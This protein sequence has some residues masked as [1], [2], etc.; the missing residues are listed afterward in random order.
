MKHLF[1]LFFICFSINANE[2]DCENVNTRGFITGNF[3]NM[4][5]EPSS[6][7]DSIGTLNKY[8]GVFIL[9]KTKVK[10]KIGKSENYWF[11][12]YFEYGIKNEPFWIF[13]DYVE[14]GDF[15]LKKIVSEIP[16]HS[17][18]SKIY[19]IISNK[20][21]NQGY[22]SNIPPGT[23]PLCTLWSYE[24]FENCIICIGLYTTVYKIDSISE[25]KNMIKIQTT[26][27]A[28]DFIEIPTGSK[29]SFEI[30]LGNDTINI[31]GAS[32]FR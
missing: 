22:W 21:E 28:S 9:E 32:Y 18:S 3:V 16:S 19:N 7:S 2:I 20:K 29:H 10:F 13:G 31:D 23:D 26:V 8:M 15:N 14:Y 11:K 30:E 27:Y 1:L 12:C 4:R 24:F 17:Y 6:L 5:T 25:S